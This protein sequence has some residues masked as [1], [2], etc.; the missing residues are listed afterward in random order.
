[1]A[2]LTLLSFAFYMPAAWA[3]AVAAHSGRSESAGSAAVMLVSGVSASEEMCITSVGGHLALES[4]ARAVREGD[5]AGFS[6]LC[7]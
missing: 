5:G 7:V 6:A 3:I 1:M 2:S 4:C